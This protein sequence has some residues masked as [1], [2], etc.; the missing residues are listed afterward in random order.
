MLALVEKN[1]YYNP[2]YQYK[3]SSPLLPHSLTH[4]LI[5]PD[6]L[7]SPPSRSHPI[8]LTQNYGGGGEGGRGQT[9]CLTQ[10]DPFEGLQQ[11]QCRRDATRSDIASVETRL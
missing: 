9:I 7:P 5:H 3:L 8:N 1:V 4:S 11:S 10:V 2:N 6:V